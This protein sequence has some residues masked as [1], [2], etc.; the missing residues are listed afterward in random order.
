MDCCLLGLV[1]IISDKEVFLNVGDSIALLDDCS[2][3]SVALCYKITIQALQT[4]AVATSPAVRYIK[5]LHT[6]CLASKGS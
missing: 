2:S 3:N 1:I 5:Q 6:T 4:L